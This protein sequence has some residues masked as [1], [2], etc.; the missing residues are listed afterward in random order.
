MR[1]PARGADV[2]LAGLT[3]RFR[4]DAEDVVGVSG[5]D[6]HIAGG[7]I[8]AVTGPSGSGKSTLLHLIG[9]MDAPDAGT[10][11]VGGVDL[12]KLSERQRAE[13]RRGVGFVFQRFHLLPALSVLDN[14]IAPVVPYRTHFDKRA[15]AQH[16]LASVGLAGRERSIPSRLSAGEQQRVAIARALINEPGLLV[17]DEPTGNLD[18]SMGAEIMQ[19]ILD[20]RSDQ[21]MTVIVATHDPLIA[22]RCDRIVRLQDG[23]VVDDLVIPRRTDPQELLDEIGRLDPRG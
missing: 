20:L 7:S 18:S 5:V 11:R 22:S 12:G 19:T 9:A 2:E 8:V 6:L 23:E 14:V 4:S 1:S 15:R 17:A 10:I 21:G 3:R 16:L 13:Y